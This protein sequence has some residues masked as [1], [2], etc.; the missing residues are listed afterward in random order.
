[1]HR[2]DPG[3]DIEETLSALTDLQR[4]GKILAFG[5]STFPAHEIVEA[6]WGGA[7]A[8]V[9]SIRHGAAAVLAA[10]PRR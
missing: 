9:G 10:R 2:P 1:V 6:A 4:Q 8:R 7:A 3:T 5:C